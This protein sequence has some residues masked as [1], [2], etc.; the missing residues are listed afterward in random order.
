MTFSIRCRSILTGLFIAVSL[1]IAS[2]AA[3]ATANLAPSKD[4]TL[5]ETPVG[6]S[7]GVGDGIYVGRVGSFGAGTQRRG[8]LA[9]DPSSIPVGSTINAVTL[10]L[11]MAQSPDAAA[12]TVTLHRASADWGEAGSSGSGSGAV[13]LSGD[14][15]WE[16]RFFSTLAWA[17]A[18]GEFAAQPSASQS[19]TGTGPYVWTGAGLVADVQFWVDNAASNFG[20]LLKGDETTTSTV[21][22]FYSRE[23]FIPPSLTIDYTPVT[24]DITGASA[25]AV[26][27][28]PPAPSPARASA[29]VS[30]SYSLPRSAR[31]SLSIHDATGRLVR[32]LAAGVTEA[33][34]RHATAWDG[35][36]ESGTKVA[37][38][39]YF[40][41]LVV[42]KHTYQRRIPLLR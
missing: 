4:N 6:N 17:T 21:K 37:S 28:A 35:R 26:W 41:N 9:F 36:T 14:A 30:L 24:T 23:G 18:G 10:S 22:K 16:F 7:N 19:V 3:A 5:I 38:G 25:E 31:V 2:G 42:S 15:T 32:R 20:W 13:A 27:F 33:A 8:M 12:R 29:P 40:A 34:G 11:E 39:V 1:S